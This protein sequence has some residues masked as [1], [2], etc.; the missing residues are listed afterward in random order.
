M[1]HNKEALA[2]E[3]RREAQ[4]D[5]FSALERFRWIRSSEG[6]KPETRPEGTPEISP[7][8]SPGNSLN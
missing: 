2:S 3:G 8:R 6:S 4:T 7:G 1:P 5:F